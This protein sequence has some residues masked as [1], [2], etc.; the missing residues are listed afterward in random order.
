MLLRFLHHVGFHQHLLACDRDLSVQVQ[1]RGCPL[2][3]GP[4]HQAHYQRKP[5]G[6]P[7]GLDEEF[8]R[9]FSFCCYLCRKR[10]TP[11][12]FRFLGR[13]VY[14]GA[15]LLLI[16]AMLGD[17][18]PRRRQRLQ[19]LCGADARTLGRWR[20]WWAKTFIRTAVWAEHSPRLGLVGGS[21]LPIP[22]QLLRYQGGR[23]L[24]HAISGALSLLLPLSTCS[25]G[26]LPD[27]HAVPWALNSRRRCE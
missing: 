14:F 19:R 9:R 6:G 2:C 7:A 13:R 3:P 22:R 26:W 23:S 5:R 25:G 15:V 4:L 21:S 16:S 20:R 17:A 12:S 18:S 24:S 8:H 11:P 1:E 10:L 27:E